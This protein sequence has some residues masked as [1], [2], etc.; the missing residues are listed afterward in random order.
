MKNIIGV[1]NI[2]EIKSTLDSMI[3]D[4][5]NFKDNVDRVQNNT[6]L[7]LGTSWVGK[8]ADE[9]SKTI[10]T[11]NN[12]LKTKADAIISSTNLIKSYIS[13]VEGAIS[14]EQIAAATLY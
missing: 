11:I 3:K 12:N 5:D 2:L 4:I 14:A 6:S 13:T 1:N 10:N 8:D 9:L 7:T